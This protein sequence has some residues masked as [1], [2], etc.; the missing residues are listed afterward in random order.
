MGFLG[1]TGGVAS[2]KSGPPSIAK[3]ELKRE[4]AGKTSS[5]A[6]SGLWKDRHSKALEAVG[7]PDIVAPFRGELGGLS[8]ARTA[9]L[10]QTVWKIL[11]HTTDCPQSYVVDVSQCIS[12]KA[13]SKD[14]LRSMTTSSYYYHFG[15]GRCLVP[16]EYMRALGFPPVNT[17]GLEPG[18]IRNLAGEAMAPPA[19]A[20]ALLSVIA[21]S[22]CWQDALVKDM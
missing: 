22:D 12:R 5:R 15:K 2:P 4:A 17:E 18:A 7:V 6:T 13:W 8:T 14:Q 16:R 11:S 20:L 19:I 1:L 21:A 9:D 10:V 3:Q